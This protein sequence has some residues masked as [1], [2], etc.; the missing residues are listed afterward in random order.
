MFLL[1]SIDVHLMCG[2]VLYNLLGICGWI[3]GNS[4]NVFL[5]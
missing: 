5:K 3:L 2:L 1:W 4:E